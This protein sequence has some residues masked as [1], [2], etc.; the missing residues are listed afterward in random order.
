MLKRIPHTD[1]E[2]ITGEQKTSDY[3]EM[4][5][6]MARFYLPKF[7]KLL[8]NQNRTGRFLEIGCGP[9]Y[10][11]VQVAKKNPNSEI[12][13]LEPS[14]DMIRVAKSYSQLQSLNGQ[15]TFVEGVVED[16]RT[17]QSLGKFDLV[18]STFS[19]HHWKDPQKA[20]QNL[21]DALKEEGVVLIF[22]FERHWLTYYLPT[23]KGIR[24]SIHASYTPK[25][26]I[27]MM[28]S[29]NLKDFQVER[30]FPYLYFLLRKSNTTI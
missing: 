11:T 27:S 24:E 18:Y 4:Q 17:I 19:L 8:E 13:A 25:D 28:T 2:I 15:T 12:V 20:I 23:R 21:Y 3:L 30:H 10:Q 5:K 9:G 26:I 6:K 1:L 29:L 16:N 14:S 22:D 7:L